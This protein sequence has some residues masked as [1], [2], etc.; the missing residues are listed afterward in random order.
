M[1]SAFILSNYF[2]LGVADNTIIL[3]VLILERVLLI[4]SMVILLVSI[5]RANHTHGMITGDDDSVY[6]TWFVRLPL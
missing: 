4:D 2:S 3:M 1:C 6:T 5:S